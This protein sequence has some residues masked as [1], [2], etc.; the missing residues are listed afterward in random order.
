MLPVET[1]LV[2]A[3]GH[4]FPLRVFA[5]AGA[6]AGLLWLPALGVPAQ[7][8]DRFAAALAQAGV[9]VAVHEWRGIGGSA[10]RARRGVDWGYAELLGQDLPASV[11]A[12]DPAVRWSFGGH[13]LGGQFAAM[14]AALSPGRSA[15]LALV[16]TGVPDARTFPAWERLLIS[17]FSR[18]LPPLTRAVGYYPGQRMGFAG[19]E[20]GQLMRDW[21]RTVRTGVYAGYGTGR[22]LEERLG[23]LKLP[24]LALRFQHD[25][26]VPEASLQGLVAKLGAGPR[27]WELFDDARLGARADH[28][29]WMRE[30]GAVAPVVAEWLLSP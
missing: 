26:F 11:A 19:R 21:A 28:F 16:A 30:P 1:P 5:P 9:A 20:A 8:Y 18:F 2:A 10:L 7:K 4:R 25:W 17:A 27:R 14:A 15:G 6:R 22:P 24:V 3:D 12:L 13:S 23:E 29:R